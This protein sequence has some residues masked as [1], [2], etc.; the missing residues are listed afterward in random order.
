MWFKRLL[1]EKESPEQF[2]YERIKYNLT[3]SSTTDKSLA[4]LNI[5]LDENM[6]LCYGDH[7]G[8][9]KLRE[10]IAARYGVAADDVNVTVGAC[11]ALFIIYSSLLK[12]GD[13]LLLMHPN[14]PANIEI[15]RSLGCQVDLYE[16]QLS[17]GFRLDVDKMI[18]MIQPETKIVS[19]TYP[20]NPTGTMISPEDLQRLCQ[21][22]EA[23]G[24]YLLVDE[25]YGDL[26][27]GERLPHACNMSDY[28]ICVESLSK[29][30]GAPGIRCGWIIT[31]NKELQEIFVAAKEQICICG[32]VVDDE[33]ACQILRQNDTIMAKIRADIA[34]KLAIVCEELDH[35]DVLE[36]VRPSAGVVCFPHIKDEIELDIAEFYDVLN[37]KYGVFVGPGHW[38]SMDDRYFRVGYAW[39]DKEQLRNGL[40]GLIAAVQDVRKN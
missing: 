27:V 28:G 29:A 31:R 38:F 22:C 6:L 39:P 2:G 32:S 26:T 14:Y 34:E 12:P 16:L 24:A 11:M 33:I 40:K 19:I 21:A 9:Q 35:Q 7:F 15:P 5:H 10:L 25:T 20:H 17:E 18:A 30:I 23:N 36:W 1:I 13:R 37:N 8:D 3:E 4:D